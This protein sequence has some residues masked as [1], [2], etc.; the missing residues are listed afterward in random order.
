M[1]RKRWPCAA[2]EPLARRLGEEK[3]SRAVIEIGY[4]LVVCGQVSDIEIQA[5]E[6]RKTRDLLNEVLSEHTGQPIE[7]IAKDTDRDY[8]M[9]ASD[10]KEYGIVD[11]I[12]TRPPASDDDDDDDDD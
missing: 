1:L 6:I 4:A 3:D 11:E 8:Y 7:Q 5:E 12:L 9:S 10:A 2:R